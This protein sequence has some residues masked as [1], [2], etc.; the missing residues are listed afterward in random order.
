MVGIDHQNKQ[1]LKP[2]T[3]QKTAFGEMPDGSKV[4]LYRLTNANG[5]QV[6]LLDYGG[7]VKEILVPDREGDF[8]NVSLGFSTIDG[9]REQSPYF[10]A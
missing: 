10:D 3:L 1:T 7:T 2:M 6:A 4:S 9:Y 5:M 8:A